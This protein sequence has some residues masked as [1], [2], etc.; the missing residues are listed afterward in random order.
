MGNATRSSSPSIVTSGFSG[1]RLRIF[2]ARM[3]LNS[4]EVVVGTIGDDLKMVYTAHGNTAG[5]GRRMEQLAAPG[6]VYLSEHCAKLVSGFFRLRDL[7]PFDLKGVNAPVRVYELEG[8]SALHTPIE[9]SR[10]RGFSR[11]VGRSDEMATLQAALAKAIAGMGQ[12]VGVVAE[13]GVGKSRLCMEFTELCRSRGIAVY[14]THG[15]SHGKAIPFLPILE[16]FRGFF[17][18]TE[19]DSN[20]AA[21]EKITG[22]MLVL[23][24]TL[25]DALARVYRGW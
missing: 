3:G 7:G 24:E 5:L 2:E 23:D 6:E 15:V 16:L 14:E 11:F 10:S 19:Q 1:G 20:Q 12:V 18:I 4:G 22:R 21:R 25:R 17:G 13:P 9:V 8:V